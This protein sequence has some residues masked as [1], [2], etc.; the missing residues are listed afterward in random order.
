MILEVTNLTFDYPGTRALDNVSFAIRD[1]S[2]T[3]LVGPNGAGK[4]T[5]LRCLAA[6]EEPMAGTIRLQGIDYSKTRG[7]PTPRSATCRISS[8]FMTNLR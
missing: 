2:I 1:G 4:T 7:L 6:L 3:A 5:L 8:V